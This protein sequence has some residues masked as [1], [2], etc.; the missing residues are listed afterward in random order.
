MQAGL[1]IERPQPSQRFQDALYRFAIFSI[2]VPLLVAGLL[3][4]FSQFCFFT[5]WLPRC[6]LDITA[7]KYGRMAGSRGGM[8][9]TRLLICYN[10][11]QSVEGV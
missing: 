1:A 11:F 10:G 4:Q 8:N 5:I 9:G 3:Q 6:Y 7:R 2:V